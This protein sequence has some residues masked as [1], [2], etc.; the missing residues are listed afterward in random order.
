M[1]NDTN[2]YN[3]NN[4]NN[5]MTYLKFLDLSKLLRGSVDY[6][7]LDSIEE[8]ILNQCAA[9][10][11]AGKPAT[12]LESMHACTD[13][14]AGTAHRRLKILRQKGFISLNV[15]E[16]DNRIKYIVQTNLCKNY[17]AQLGKC[18]NG[19]LVS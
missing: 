10:W 13:I 11:L 17:F 15:D 3:D 1:K 9:A 18:I 19:A 7:E 5:L 8:R 6:P 4:N 16:T 2:N 14:S 12:V